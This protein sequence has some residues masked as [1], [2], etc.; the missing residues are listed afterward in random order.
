[1]VRGEFYASSLV[2]Q[3][4]E[5]LREIN[6]LERGWDGVRG[7]APYARPTQAA[8]LGELCAGVAVSLG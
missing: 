3:A 1:M 7:D 2:A 6:E 5:T 4:G 8:V